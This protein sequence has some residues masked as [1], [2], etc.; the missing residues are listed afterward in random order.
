MKDRKKELNVQYNN[1][2]NI[3]GEVNINNG[4]LNGLA[5]WLQQNCS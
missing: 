5:C 4:V 2:Y 1:T 3:C